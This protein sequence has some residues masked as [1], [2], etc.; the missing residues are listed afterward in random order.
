MGRYKQIRGPIA[1]YFS[2]D[3]PHDHEVD[4][5][6]LSIATASRGNLNLELVEWNDG[7]E[8]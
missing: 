1:I 8:H 4:H 5:S 3:S 7:M 2:H 6:R